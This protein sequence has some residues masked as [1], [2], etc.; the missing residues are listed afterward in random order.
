M[1]RYL[2]LILAFISIGCNGQKEVIIENIKN[3][4]EVKLPLDIEKLSSYKGEMLQESVAL[5]LSN[6][7]YLLNIK[8]T[9]TKNKPLPFKNAILIGKLNLNSAFITAVFRRDYNLGDVIYYLCNFNNQGKL[10]SALKIIDRGNI[11]NVFSIIDSKGI[12]CLKKEYED[13]IEIY[14]FILDNDGIFKRT[15]YSEEKL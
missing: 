5:K 2:V 1:R 14:T 8:D 15:E 11:P 4:T 10:L 6:S 12:I 7:E 3:S 13:R 9:V